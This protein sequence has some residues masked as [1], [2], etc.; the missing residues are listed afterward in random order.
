ME[1]FKYQQTGACGRVWS[2]FAKLSEISEEEKL[3]KSASEIEYAHT[4]EI[5]NS[6]LNGSLSLDEY[7]IRNFNLSGYEYKCAENDRNGE[8]KNTEKLL[9]IVD[10]FGDTKDDKVGFGDISERKLEVVEEAFEILE[11]SES[12]KRDIMLLCNVRKKYIRE[13]GVDLTCIL[14]NSLRGIPE[15]KA[16]LMGIISEKGNSQVKELV[17]SLCENSGGYLISRLECTL[18]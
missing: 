18:Q 15:A 2:L 14:L 7:N 1:Y 11:N 5:V 16:Q 4:L 3:K 8:I 12:F 10:N 9:Y 13:R 17:V 6:A